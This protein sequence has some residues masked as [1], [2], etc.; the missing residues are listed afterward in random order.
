[1]L[2]RIF[3]IKMASMHTTNHYH[4]RQGGDNKYNNQPIFNNI[5]NLTQR[6][7]YNNNNINKYLNNKYDLLN[8][9]IARQELFFQ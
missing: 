7:N 6:N 9:G 4:R 3:V 5:D 1:M 2:L 8:I